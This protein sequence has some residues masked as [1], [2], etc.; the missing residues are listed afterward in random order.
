MDTPD[1]KIAPPRAWSQPEAFLAVLLLA[2][3]GDVQK[4]TRRARAV[5]EYVR[6]AP[7]LRPLG[8]KG[9]TAL[10][11]GVGAHLSAESALAEACAVI[12]PAIAPSLYAQA[13]DILIDDEVVC[14]REEALIARLEDLL[15]LDAARAAQIREI[16]TLK[17]KY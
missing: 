16:T 1:P 7:F 8:E 12:D 6:R 10:R 3:V 17:N 2:A 14:P 15:Y 11:W 9:R 5:D 4:H 13:L